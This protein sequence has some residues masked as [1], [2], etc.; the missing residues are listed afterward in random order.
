MGKI[1]ISYRRSDSADATGRIYDRLIRH[2]SRSQ[3]FKDVDNIPAAT[4]YKAVIMDSMRASNIL[5][6]IIGRDWVSSKDEKGNTRLLLPE[7]PIR[8]EIEHAISQG[9]TIFPVL[10]ENAK[11]PDKDD[12]PESIQ[13]ISFQNAVPVRPDPDFDNDIKKLVEALEEIQSGK[14]VL[15]LH[16]FRKYPKYI[17]GAA[18]V[19]AASFFIFK[20]YVTPSGQSEKHLL[21]GVV[22]INQRPADSILVSILEIQNELIT[23]KFGSYRDTVSA[24]KVKSSYTLSFDSRKIRLR[25]TMVVLEGDARFRQ[26]RFYLNVSNPPPAV[27][28]EPE[29]D[30][31]DSTSTTAVGT[32]ADI[33]AN[34]IVDPPAQSTGT[35]AN[36]A[37]V[38]PGSARGDPPKP[39]TNPT[40]QEGGSGSGKDIRRDIGVRPGISDPVVKRRS[41]AGAI[42]EIPVSGERGADRRLSE[43]NRPAATT[44]GV[45]NRVAP[46]S[47]NTSSAM[48]RINNDSLV[49]VNSARKL[50]QQK[51]YREA[52]VKFE[53]AL[54]LN[55]NNADAFYYLGMCNYNEKAFDKAL[56]NFT[57]AIHVSSVNTTDNQRSKVYLL[58]GHTYF[59]LGRY[60]EACQDYRMALSLGLEEARPFVANCK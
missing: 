1:F 24:G 11:M 51:N 19:L 21:E 10:V 6:L 37:G 9:L 4:N 5:L 46:L 14:S 32:G 50:Y 41:S 33:S 26:Q 22:L 15:K 39:A 53:Q 55:R 43:V 13:S 38:E 36:P 58:R 12:L 18:V 28:N 59:N 40:G 42:S 29:P 23:D 16:R 8:F 45:E 48:V 35:P 25:D 57:D 49:L 30:P 44:G 60:A 56:K 31:V 54:V 2:F 34:P 7:D 52:A 47:A 17:V 20:N 27:F 3:I